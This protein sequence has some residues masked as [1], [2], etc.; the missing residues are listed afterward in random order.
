[1]SIYNSPG[2][3]IAKASSLRQL[4]LPSTRN[5]QIGGPFHLFGHS[6]T[7]ASLRIIP[8]AESSDTAMDTQKGARK[9]C[10][11]SNIAMLHPAMQ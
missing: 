11:L 9:L 2:N 4:L 8:R 1:M 7:L 6:H 5:L 3:V 10:A